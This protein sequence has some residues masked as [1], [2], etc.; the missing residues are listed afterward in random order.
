MLA[1]YGN[2]LAADERRREDLFVPEAQGYPFDADPASD[3]WQAKVVSIG[4]P[5]RQASESGK[6]GGPG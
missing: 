6:S 5:C 4:G 2:R 3:L 1:L